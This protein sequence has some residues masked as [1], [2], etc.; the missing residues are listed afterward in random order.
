MDNKETILI[1]LTTNNSASCLAMSV[2]S[3]G[4]VWKYQWPKDPITE[5]LQKY[6]YGDIQD[7]LYE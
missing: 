7:T 5:L 3:M 1:A 4:R 2:V 6:V